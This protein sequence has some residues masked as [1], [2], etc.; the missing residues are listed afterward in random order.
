MSYCRT[1]KLINLTVVEE[2]NPPSKNYLTFSASGKIPGHSS[3]LDLDKEY[4]KLFIGGL[5]TSFEAPIDIK[6]P[7]FYGQVEELVVEGIAA[8]LWNFVEVFTP[9]AADRSTLINGSIER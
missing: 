9:P 4:S 3:V 1:G 7:T 8:G 6:N 5:P 2:V